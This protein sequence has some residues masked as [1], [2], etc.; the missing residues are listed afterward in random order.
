MPIVSDSRGGS[1]RH[2]VAS[3]QRAAPDYQLVPS[4]ELDASSCVLLAV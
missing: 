2:G 4:F 3:A 1:I